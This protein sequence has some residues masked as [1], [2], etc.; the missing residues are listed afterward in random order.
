MARKKQKSVK[1]K[2]KMNRGET[3]QHFQDFWDNEVPYA[4]SKKGKG[5][6]VNPGKDTFSPIPLVAK[7]YAQKDYIASIEHDTFTIGI[8]YAGTGKTYL[9]ARV[10]G[11]MYRTG[12]LNQIILTRP[13]VVCG[14]ELGHLPGTIEEKYEPY[15]QPFKTGL[16][17]AIGK[18]KFECDKYKNIIPMPLQYMRGMSFDNTAILLD[19]AQNITVEQMKMFITRVGVNCKIIISGDTRQTDLKGDSGLAWLVRELRRQQKPVEIIEFRREDCVR[20]E[21]CQM[22]LDLIEHA[23]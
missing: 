17:E 16:V 4:K 12:E 11:E 21:D 6:C 18:N 20:S 8:G 10:V 1:T 19:E 13:T 22:M 9:A 14:D 5:R 2:R 3:P 7:N 15:I 23:D